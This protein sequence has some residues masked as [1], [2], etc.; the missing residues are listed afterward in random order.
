MNGTGDSDHDNDE[1]NQPEAGDQGNNTEELVNGVDLALSEANHTL[2][3]DANGDVD[4]D[5]V[6]QPVTNGIDILTAEGTVTNPD[7]DDVTA[8]TTLANSTGNSTPRRTRR[9][10][11]DAGVPS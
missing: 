5:V 3:S 10:A 1:P 8:T 6:D 11:A 7:N 9:A 2:P 4:V